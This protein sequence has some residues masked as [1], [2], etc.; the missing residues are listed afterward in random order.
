MKAKGSFVPSRNQWNLKLKFRTPEHNPSRVRPVKPQSSEWIPDTDMKSLMAL[1]A[2]G[3]HQ[4]QLARPLWHGH[5]LIFQAA[6]WCLPFSSPPALALCGSASSKPWI[7]PSH[8]YASETQP[9]PHI[10]P[11]Q[12]SPQGCKTA[13]PSSCMML[14]WQHY[15]YY[16]D[17]NSQH[18]LSPYYMQ[19]TM[20]SSLHIFSNLW[21]QYCFHQL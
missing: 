20:H 10:C 1:L 17:N 16:T 8:R 14:Y 18:V 2:I 3:W 21:S 13:L 4:A 7:L 5:L 15:K 12:Q 6:T 19:A 9:V 11:N